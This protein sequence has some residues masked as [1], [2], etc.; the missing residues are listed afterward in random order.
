MSQINNKKTEINQRR[1]LEAENK[2]LRGLC[3]D[4]HQLIDMAVEK[5]YEARDFI[6]EIRNRENEIVEKF[7]FP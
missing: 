1:D 4:Y 6:K 5:I 3:R 7:N 2:R